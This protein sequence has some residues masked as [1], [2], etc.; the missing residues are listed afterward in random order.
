[1][2]K[3]EKSAQASKTRK[4]SRILL[5]PEPRKRL[6]GMKEKL[7]ITERIRM[8]PT[9]SE[10]RRTR[11]WSM[12]AALVNCR[13]CFTEAEDAS[14]VLEGEISA[15]VA[16]EMLNE[17][18]KLRWQFMVLFVDRQMPDCMLIVVLTN[19]SR[20]VVVNVRIRAKRY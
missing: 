16:A 13:F 11:K 8:A 20:S 7:R 17:C 12:E 4:M 15:K 9:A 2:H 18:R 1:M 5:K 14:E 10:R 19:R 6:R 3:A